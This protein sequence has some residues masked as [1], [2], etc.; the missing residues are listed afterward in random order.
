MV[1]VNA[2]PAGAPFCYC[3]D[4]EPAPNDFSDSKMVGPTNA[5]GVIVATFD[6]VGGC[7]DMYFYATIGIVTAGP[8][9]S[10]Y[11]ANVDN[12]GDCLVDLIDFG[13]FASSY[14][15]D[16][17]CSDYDCSGQVTLIDFGNF[18]SHYLHDC[19]SD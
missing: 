4:G 12:N 19:D 9:L 16:D 14:M 10:I 6:K 11:I 7:G 8:S 13:N 2:N 17:G 1:T 3:A 18:A 15:S 5:A